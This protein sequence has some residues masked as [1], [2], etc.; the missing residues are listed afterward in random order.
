[1]NLFGFT[2]ASFADMREYFD[3]FL[4]ALPDGEKKAECLAPTYVGDRVDAGRMRVNVLT[5][6]ATWFGMTYAADREFTH[7]CL[8][9]LHEQGVYPEKLF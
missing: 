5:T 9:R 8:L 3:D 4:R 6:D 2:K 1:M 7:Q